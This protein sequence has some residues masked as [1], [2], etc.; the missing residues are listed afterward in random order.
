MNATGGVITDV[1]GRR[2]HTFTTVGASTFTVNSGGMIEVLVVAGGGSGGMRHA[3]GGGAGGLIFTTLQMSPGAYTVTVG[4]GGA[5]VPTGGTNGPGNS[6]ANSVFGSLTAIGGGYGSQV[7]GGAGGS[8]GG[9]MNNDTPV[10]AGTAGQGNNGAFGSTGPFT[11]ENSFGGGGGGGA[12]AVGTASTSVTP[13]QAGAGGIGL[14]YSISGTATYYAGGGGGGTATTGGSI[15]GAGGVG[16]GGAGGGSNSTVGFAGTIGTGG[17]G[18]AGGFNGG[19]NYASG[20]GGSGIIII[21]YALMSPGGVPILS[22]ISLESAASAVGLYSLRALRSSYARVVQIRRGQPTMTAATTLGYTASASSTAQAAYSGSNANP[23]QAFDDNITTFWEN[24]YGGNYGYSTTGTYVGTVP[25]GG[26]FYTT[27]GT[28]GTYNGEWLQIQMPTGILLQNYSIQARGGQ[29]SSKSPNTFVILGSNDGTTWTLLD[30]QSGITAASWASQIVVTFTIASPGTTKYTYFRMVVQNVQNT[31]SIQTV[32]IAQWTLINTSVSDFYADTVG[33]LTT[34]SGETLLNWL[35]GATGFVATLYDQ[36]TNGYVLTQ[37]TTANQPAINLATTPYSMIFNGSNW[38]LNTSVPFNMGLGSFTLRYVVSNN[39]GGC[40]FSKSIG[41]ASWSNPSEKKFWLG[42]GTTAESSTGNYPSQVG[43]SEGWT[44]SST[45]ITASVKNSIV[46]KA[47]S[48]KFA[49]IYVNGT[50]ASV[51]TITT[52]MGNDPGNY[53]VIGRGGSPFINYSGNLFELE[54]FSTPLLDSELVILD[55]VSFATPSGAIGESIYYPTARTLVNSNTTVT[56][57][58]TILVDRTAQGAYL[59]PSTSNATAI[60]QW[61]QRTVNNNSRPYWSNTQTTNSFKTLPTTT[62]TGGAF[63]G[64]VL[65]PDGRVVFVPQVQSQ[66]G[67]FDPKTNALTL[68]ATVTEAGSTYLFNSGCLLPDGRVFFCPWNAT[69]FG[70]FNPASGVYTSYAS[71]NMPTNNFNYSGCVVAPNGKVVC[72]PYRA[73][74]IGVFDPVTNTFTT[75][76][77]P[78]VTADVSFT[79]AVAVPDGRVIMV[80]WGNNINPAHVGIFNTIT[81]TYTTVSTGANAFQIYAG[82]VLVPDGRIIMI[83]NTA[84]NHIGVFN[85]NTN[86]FSTLP[87]SSI[88]QAYF[89]GCLLPDGTVFFSP[90]SATNYGIFNPST[91]IFTTVTG[92][93]NPPG[94]RAYNGCTLLLDGRVVMAPF[95]S[96]TIG[97]LSGSNRPVPR[98]F[99]LHPFF[100]KN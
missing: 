28:A 19:T 2:I 31:G 33:N 48:S 70:V 35:G 95:I 61:V 34:A 63:I 94:S 41:F 55:A 91:N 98:E 60:T 25:S 38:L 71:A 75:Y 76:A 54:L 57:N 26:A 84:Q 74:N 36:S 21:S 59:V 17:G 83:P 80:P 97:I 100:N 85:T 78:G 58:A 32:D 39:T 13:V 4:D 73:N 47:I 10:G 99:C 81:N 86:I 3:G 40:V 44:I 30:T 16:G 22:R 51:G 11:G 87:A 93:V 69:R 89:G 14:Q 62:N 50:Q 72:A 37:S 79:G 15:G 43:Y 53:V 92:V 7:S 24:F 52:S 49:P 82:G 23:W 64:G 29:E 46:H 56:A 20:K 27:T 6:G 42:N 68:S 77:A 67:I 66:V 96:Q 65:I 18:G 1:N 5:S 12:G 90:Q 45:A 8:G 88:N 9:I